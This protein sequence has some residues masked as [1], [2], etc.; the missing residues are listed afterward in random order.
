MSC[1]CCGHD[2]PGQHDLATPAGAAVLQLAQ[3]MVALQ[4][5]LICADMGQ[6][7]AALS[8]LPDHLRL[9]RAEPGCLRFE[10][11]QDEDP[12]I[13]HLSELFTSP[14]AFAAH[15]ARTRASEWGQ[16]SA[17]MGRD[18]HQHHIQPH[19]RPET[20]ADHAALDDLLT[21]AFGGPDEARLLRALRDDGDL[22]LS[23]VAE[24]AGCILG[25]VA[26]SP[27]VAESPAQALAPLA[28]L[29]AMQGMGIGTALVRQA[30]AGAGGKAVVVLGD[31]AYYSRFGFC[32]ADLASPWAGTHLQVRGS[33]P[34]GSAVTHAR[35][36]GARQAGG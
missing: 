10:M 19:I 12:M 30:L 17:G 3:P 21:A 8:L 16:G 15:Q 6:M 33:L 36:F 4:G 14:G 27:L 29:P 32:P 18:F 28:V 11:W 20:P 23:L 24:A 22:S 26:L 31:P 35:A 34:A 13:W 7:M 9:S 1:T 2:H 5:R 25:H